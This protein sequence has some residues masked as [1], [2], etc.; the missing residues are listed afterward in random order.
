MSLQTPWCFTTRCRRIRQRFLSGCWWNLKTTHIYYSQVMLQMHIHQVQYCD[1]VVFTNVELLVTRT[2][3]DQPFVE[4][5]LQKCRH[6]WYINILREMQSRE[7]AQDRML[8]DTVEEEQII[9]S[10]R[11][12]RFGRT[13]KCANP[14]CKISKFHYT[15]VDIER[16]PKGQWICESCRWHVRWYCC[17]FCMLQTLAC[18]TCVCVFSLV[19]IVKF[20]KKIFVISTTQYIGDLILSRNS[21]IFWPS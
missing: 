18:G 19:R 11:S 15:C 1:F 20:C 5:M 9:Y 21:C 2:K 17:L 10:C 3:L 6:F 16:K 13:I 4:N 8:Q 7:I 14:D 12:P